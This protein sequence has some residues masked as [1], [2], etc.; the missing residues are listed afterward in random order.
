MWQWNDRHSHLFSRTVSLHKN[1]WWRFRQCW[2]NCRWLSSQASVC[3]PLFGAFGFSGVSSGV[4]LSA[5]LLRS[6]AAMTWAKLHGMSLNHVILGC[7]SWLYW[8]CQY[9]KHALLMW[10]CIFQGS[11][12]QFLEEASLKFRVPVLW[13]RF[14]RATLIPF[15]SCSTLRAGDSG[16]SLGNSVA[17]DAIAMM[18]GQ[19]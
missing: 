17:K 15:F 6:N 7:F 16:P 4:A 5:A 19:V 18:H 12:Q 13:N 3:L 14:I 8:F 11:R 1:S 10:K 2:C 9:I